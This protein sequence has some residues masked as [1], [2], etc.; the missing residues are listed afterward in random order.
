M[1][2]S[3]GFTLLEL[4]IVVA[5]IAI[6]AVLAIS[7]YSKQVRKSRRAEAKQAIAAVA[8]GEEKWRMNNPNYGT[9]DQAFT[10]GTCASYNTS[11]QWYTVAISG[12]PNTTDYT[13]TATP[14][15][16]QTKDKCGTFT[17]AMASG[18]VTKS[19]TTPVECKW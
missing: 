14:K 10:P 1:K 13:I 18:V 6:L 16:D 8:M 17:Y 12:T 2:K 3:R 4:M 7:Q 9:C 19:P 15:L 5:V 11:L